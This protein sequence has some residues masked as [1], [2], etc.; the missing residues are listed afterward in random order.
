MRDSCP[1]GEDLAAYAGGGLMPVE[2]G[3]I[4]SHLVKC[5]D[6]F[7]AV[8]FVMRAREVLPPPVIPKPETPCRKETS[9]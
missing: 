2:R 8:V 5:N 7:D 9:F 6:C 1:E 4:E 3:P